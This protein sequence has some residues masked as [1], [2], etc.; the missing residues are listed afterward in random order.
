[1][2][3]KAQFD[4]ARKTIYWMITGFVITLIILAFVLILAN[5]KGRVQSVPPELNAE[6]ISLRFTNIPECF[7]YQ[8]PVTNRIYSGTIDIKKFTNERMKEFCYTTNDE[9]GHN[10]FNFGLELV[11]AKKKINTNNYYQAPQFTFKKNVLVHDGTKFVEDVLNI[12]T[13]VKVSSFV[14]YK[15]E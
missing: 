8:D 9:K 2:N 4:V 5:F 13:Q 15:N 6:F 10:D 14:R 12:H 1:M 7:A 3:K 11:T